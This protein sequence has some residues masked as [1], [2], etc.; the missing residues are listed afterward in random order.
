MFVRTLSAARLRRG[1][2]SDAVAAR[3]V[4]LE[5]IQ[6]DLAALVLEHAQGAGMAAVRRDGAVEVAGTLRQ[7]QTAER[8]ASPVPAAAAALRQAAQAVRRALEP[9]PVLR[10]G[11]HAIGLEGAVVM[12]ILNVAKESF[13]DGGRYVGVDRAL[14]RA[15]QMAAEGA[16]IIDIGGQ[17]YNHLTPPVDEAEE[18]ARV[19]PVVEAL[20]RR[21]PRLPLSVDTVR[22]GVALAV[23]DAGAAI[24][25]DCS[26]NADPRMAAACARYAAA[27]VVMHLKGRLKV[28]EPESYVYDDVVAEIVRFLDV[29]SR[30]ALEAGVRAESLVVDPGLEFGK[31]PADDLAIVERLDELLVLGYPVLVAASRK[32]FMGRIFDLPAA[33][34]LAPSAAVAACSVLSGARI[35]RAHDVQ[36]TARLV[37]MLQ[38]VASERKREL[39]RAEAMPPSRPPAGLSSGD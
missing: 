27:D 35:V 28:R 14:E 17:S 8:S 12:G 31:E 1:S 6:D 4:V 5:G 10:A 19:V 21:F 23:L 9:A 39:V 20:V 7:L 36:F 26:G 3:C 11:G 37:A 22:S 29:R 24:V 30:A 25:N 15:E 33:E 16:G 13:Y 34:L 38:A 18:I 2:L 32:S